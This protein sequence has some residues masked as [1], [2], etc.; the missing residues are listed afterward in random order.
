[1]HKISTSTPYVA[2]SNIKRAGNG[3]FAE[4]S[5]KY[6][7]IVCTYSG[8]IMDSPPLSPSDYI[9]QVSKTLY[10]DGKH[11]GGLGRYINEHPDGLNN[12]RFSWSNN[13]LFIRVVSKN[14]AMTNL[15]HPVKQTVAISKGSEFYIGYG[16][17]YWKDKES[18]EK[19]LLQIK[20]ASYR[21]KK[22]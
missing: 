15:A 19:Q 6:N 17:S 18:L 14:Y 7:E 20:K 21:K 10:I 4:R 11:K 3:L 5:Y 9:V 12:V 1:M 13:T 16:E 22:F 2:A 8:K